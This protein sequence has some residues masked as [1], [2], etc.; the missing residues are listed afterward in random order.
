MPLSYDLDVDDTVGYGVEHHLF[1]K[2]HS[3]AHYSYGRWLDRCAAHFVRNGCCTCTPH[4]P[5]GMIMDYWPADKE[6]KS[7]YVCLIMPDEGLF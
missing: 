7:H 4:C 1:R 5:D 2:M 3:E 6:S